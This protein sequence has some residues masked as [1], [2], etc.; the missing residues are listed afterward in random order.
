MINLMPPAKKEAISYARHNTRLIS[1]LIGIGFAAAGLVLIV[2]GGLFYLK[3]DSKTLQKSIA[4]TK[5]SLLAQ[6]EKATL[7]R[8]DEISGRLSLVVDVLSKEVLFSKLLPHVGALMP[9][10]TILRD[11]SLSREQEGGID[12]SIGAVDY[13]SASQA[14]VNLQDSR[15]LLFTGADANKIDCEGGVA[16]AP[17]VCTATIRAV[18]AEDNPFL[19]LNQ[20]A[21]DVE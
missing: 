18:M 17:Y 15:S 3:Q 19:L 16:D 8:I 7:E 5:Q 4:E 14:L 1:W 12:L 11:L 10:G 9:E 13:L 21:E 20:G 2:G 6:D